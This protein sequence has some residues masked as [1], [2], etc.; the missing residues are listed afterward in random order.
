MISYSEFFPEQRQF[1]NLLTFQMHSPAY[2]TITSVS[3]LPE[4]LRCKYV[5]KRC[6][7]PR[8]NKKSGGLHKFCAV[9][10][11]KANRNQ[12]RLDHRRRMTKRMQQ[13]EGHWHSNPASVSREYA[14]IEH[15]CTSKNG[16][17]DERVA[18][19]ED[20]WLDLMPF[21]LH[22]KERI[23]SSATVNRVKPAFDPQD[24]HI[25][26]EL[27]FSDGDESGENRTFASMRRNKRRSR[28]KSSTP[29]L[30]M[31]LTV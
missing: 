25:L 9:H 21:V 26:E 4:E 20:L 8:T 7:N 11:E 12:M 27:L 19:P 23:F 22:S 2:T 14:K 15:E 30:P 6:E 18:K 3:V 13:R 28:A 10:R 24:L 31:S 5:S 1:S 16:C 17:D 29:W